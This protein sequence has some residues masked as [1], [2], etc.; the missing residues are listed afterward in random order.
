MAL[1]TDEPVMRSSRE[2]WTLQSAAPVRE[3]ELNTKKHAAR[4]V[5]Y[6]YNALSLMKPF[7]SFQLLLLFPSGQ[8]FSSFNLTHAAVSY[9]L[10][11]SSVFRFP[12]VSSC[13]KIKVT[14][15][16]KG[17]IHVWGTR[18]V[19][20]RFIHSSTRWGSRT[21]VVQIGPGSVEVNP[22]SLH[23][24]QV[25]S[26]YFHFIVAPQ[27]FFEVWVQTPNGLREC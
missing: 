18:G 20:P 23:Q 22:E 17:Y 14:A 9:E 10:E 8:S 7:D 24:S 25:H 2:E 15:Y 5:R 19:S 21:S 4:H 16:P 3:D 6:V 1:G 13:C 26:P 27:R 11:Y 12:G